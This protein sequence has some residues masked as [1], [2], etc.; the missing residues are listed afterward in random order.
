MD[1]GG[2]IRDKRIL[3]YSCLLI[4]R[5]ADNASLNVLCI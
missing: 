1:K 5:E 3:Y 2:L 4:L